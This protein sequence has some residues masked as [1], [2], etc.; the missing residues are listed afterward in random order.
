MYYVCGIFVD[1]QSVS[2]SVC[3]LGSRF[4]NQVVFFFSQRSSRK[5]IPRQFSM[6]SFDRRTSCTCPY[7]KFDIWAQ[8]LCEK[9]VCT[10]CAWTSLNILECRPL[11]RISVIHFVCW[12]FPFCILQ[13]NFENLRAFVCLWMSLCKCACAALC[14]CMC[15]HAQ[16]KFTES[17]LTEQ[18]Y[19]TGDSWG[20]CGLSLNTLSVW[21]PDSRGQPC[22]T[23][24]FI[25]PLAV[26][27]G[28]EDLHFRYLVDLS[29]CSF[30]VPS[31]ARESAAPLQGDCMASAKGGKSSRQVVVFS[32]PMWLEGL[33][34]RQGVRKEDNIGRSSS[35]W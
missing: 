27:L 4:W 17:Y 30:V 19:S 20:G 28:L 3:P 1:S 8:Q 6:H 9:P 34:D 32:V 29:T 25:P 12:L 26:L 31:F 23:W 21:L 13:L 15:L 5:N 11:H 7:C 35:A 2:F 16:I 22:C 14:L 33:Q 24:V 10:T 18:D